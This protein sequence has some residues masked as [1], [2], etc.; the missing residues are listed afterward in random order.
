M[1][2][3]QSGIQWRTVDKPE[4]R[5]S[6]EGLL[7]RGVVVATYTVDDDKLYPLPFQVTDTPNTPVSIYCDVLCYTSIPGTRW[8][9]IAKALVLQDKGSIHNGRI[10]KPKATTLEVASTTD[11][12]GGA[13]PAHFDGDHVLVG[14][15][16]GNKNQP[17]ILGGVPHPSNNVGNLDKTVGHR[18]QLKLA[19]GDPDFFKHHGTFYGITNKGDWLVD[20]TF[21]NDGQLDAVGHE[22]APPTNGYGSQKAFLPKDAA[23]VIDFMDMSNPAA[24]LSKSYLAISKDIFDLELGGNIT[25]Q[26]LGTGANAQLQVGDGSKHVPI[27]EE[28][29]QLW[30]FLKIWLDTHT[31]PVAVAVSVDTSTGIGT[32]SGTAAQPTVVSPA[33]SNVINS[34]KVSIPNG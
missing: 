8:V 23:Y 18:T 2:T 30:N 17:I 9:P 29:A 11:V 10:W 4:E 20:T 1:T 16:D 28:L 26:A 6:A 34:T 3:R 13:N 33:W 19:D 32:G 14:F 12:D 22:P 21:A 31:H 27:V 25:L 5:N 7:L 24:P 15:V